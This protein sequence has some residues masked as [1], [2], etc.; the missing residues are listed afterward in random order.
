MS[1]DNAENNYSSIDALYLQVLIKFPIKRKNRK[2][3]KKTY[4][5]VNGFKGLKKTITN[6]GA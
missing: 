4:L 5:Q 2:K 6:N 3:T 1:K